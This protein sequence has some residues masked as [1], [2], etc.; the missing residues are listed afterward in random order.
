MWCGGPERNAT[1]TF[2]ILSMGGQ[3]SQQTFQPDPSA[4]AAA[5]PFPRLGPSW[6]S[7]SDAIGHWAHRTDQVSQGESEGYDENPF[8]P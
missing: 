5:F 3:P 6:K 2:L 7:D 8:P 1:W 4:A